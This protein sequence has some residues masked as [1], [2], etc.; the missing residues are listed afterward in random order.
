MKT[1]KESKFVNKLWRLKRRL[2]YLLGLKN[3]VRAHQYILK[4]HLQKLLEG[5]NN[6]TVIETGCIR[7]LNEGTESTLTISSTLEGRGTFYTFELSKENIETCK[8]ICQD[9]N[10]YITYVQGDSVAN[11][12]KMVK[13]KTLKS[14]DFAFF[15]SVNDGD[16]IFK[17]FK[18]VENL[19]NEGS[20]AVFDD[21]LWED[22]GR[23]IKPYLESSPNW[24]TK[25][26]NVENGIL[27]AEKS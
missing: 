18:V 27:V 3:Y 6:P 19:F 22:K 15:D 17:E 26:Y 23:L 9:H 2:L 8:K 16:H 20:V 24:K 4:K 13:S 10:R 5:E 7:D 14:V 25:T 21:V 1:L 11:L 12:K